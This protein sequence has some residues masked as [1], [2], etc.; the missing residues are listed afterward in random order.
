MPPKFNKTRL[1]SAKP[2][3]PTPDDEP[4]A[5]RVKIEKVTPKKKTAVAHRASPGGK[6]KSAMKDGQVDMDESMPLKEAHYKQYVHPDAKSLFNQVE[7]Y[8]CELL[9]LG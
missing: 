6:G 3:D 5:K 4:D 8:H 7:V 1:G 2:R 9:I